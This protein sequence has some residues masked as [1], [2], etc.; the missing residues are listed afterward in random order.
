MFAMR[1]W[2][3]LALLPL[4]LALQFLGVFTDNAELFS[5]LYLA[6][7]VACLWLSHR[8]DRLVPVWPRPTTTREVRAVAALGDALWLLPLI[9]LLNMRYRWLALPVR[10]DMAQVSY[11]ILWSMAGAGLS[12]WAA[13][14]LGSK[15]LRPSS[16]V[17]FGAQIGAL[18][19][20]LL[21]VRIPVQ[22]MPLFPYSTV[23]DVALWLALAALVGLISRPAKSVLRFT[24]LVVLLGVALRVMGMQVWQVDPATRDMLALIQSAQDRFMAGGHPYGL[25][26]MQPGSQVPLTY[27]PGMWL[28]YGLPRLLGLDLRWAGIAADLTIVASMVWVVRGMA[29][30]RKAW[31]QAAVALFC[32]TWFFLPSM[33]WNGVYA[34]PHVWWGCLALLLACVVTESWWL[35]AVALGVAIC[36]RHFGILLCPFVFLAGARALGWRP[37]LLR[38]AVTSMIVAALVG[39]FALTDPDAFWLGTFRW[40][41]EYGPIHQHWFIHKIGLAGVF[42]RNGVHAWLGLFQLATLFAVVALAWRRSLSRRYVV[43]LAGTALILFIMFNGLIWHSFYLDTSIFL[44]FALLDGPRPSEA[45]T[46]TPS[47]LAVLLVMGLLLSMVVG[48]F[49]LRDMRRYFDRSD[50]KPTRDWLASQIQSGDSIVDA[51]GDRVAFVRD[52]HV[53]RGLQR[54]RRV[55]KSF[56]IFDRHKG[57]R[58]A[59]LSKR[60]WLVTKAGADLTPWYRLG[61]PMA[62]KDFGKFALL[63]LNTHKHLVSLSKRLD[64]L[65]PSVGPVLGGPTQ[66]MVAST[67]PT[68]G[69]GTWRATNGPGWLTVQGRRCR[70]GGVVRHMVDVRPDGDNVITLVWK[71]I[72][73][74]Q[75][76]LVFGGLM[77][78]SIDWNRGAVQV[79]INVGG[80]PTGALRIANHPGPQWVSLDTSQITGGTT[81]VTFTVA[82][83]SALRRW[84][85]VD[86]WVLD[87]RFERP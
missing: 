61:E 63:G 84:V 25:Y 19:A 54:G 20:A 66:A 38:L 39:P 11:L 67:R 2:I 82:T 17:R 87:E 86:A 62:R 40:L 24:A 65:R 41:R 45:P 80:Q 18:F 13:P 12:N 14:T 33:H 85:C 32:C 5:G 7:F 78:R 16:V 43:P 48:T 49:L 29:A 31:G 36:T 47:W 68:S 42:Y 6:G 3:P 71:N 50:L 23:A 9:A 74:G 51:S 37:A 77:D 83:Q 10:Y 46:R 72:T 8:Q 34:E 22:G 27:L 55:L 28:L 15:G 81:T 1:Y 21:V 44:A 56:D 57:S 4:F 58:D 70:L 53:L 30:P 60:M 52:P 69:S 79:D 26:Q 73:M 59:L 76:L 35:A 75:T 64:M